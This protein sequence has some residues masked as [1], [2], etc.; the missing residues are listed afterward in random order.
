LALDPGNIEA[1]VGTAITDTMSGTGGMAHDRSARLA[2]A[3]AA[4]TRVLSLAPEHA[5]AHMYLGQ[6]QLHTNRAALG[7]AECEQAL[8]LNR[9]L[10][11]AHAEIGQAMYFIGRG[12]ETETYVQAAFRLSPRDTNAYIWIA[13]TALAKLYLS[14]D[15]DAVSRFRR[16]IEANR[17]FPLAHFCLAAALAHLDRL[18]EARSAVQAGLALDPTFTI[19]RFRNSTATDN[20]T[21]LAG[22]EHIYEGMRKAGVPEG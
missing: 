19:S 7:I 9:N 17:N 16:S 21:Y 1:L 8:T 6:V 22:R 13:F 2:A 12:E 18:A 3:E 14:S 5:L 11:Y 4:L 20:R 15:E 10:A